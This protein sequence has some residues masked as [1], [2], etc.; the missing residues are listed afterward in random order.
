M[1]VQAPL[2]EQNVGTLPVL[3]AVHL[4]GEDMD[5][6]HLKDAMSTDHKTRTDD[7]HIHEQDKRE[8]KQSEKEE[9]NTD[10]IPKQAE[11]FV[12]GNKE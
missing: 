2:R 9:K 11:R 8:L 6:R 3:K 12:P 7:E 1:G 10:L 4:R 5:P